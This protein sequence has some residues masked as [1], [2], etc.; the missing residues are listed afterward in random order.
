[1]RNLVLLL[2]FYYSSSCTQ[3]LHALRQAKFLWFYPL[4]RSMHWHWH[5]NIATVWKKFF[6][7]KKFFY[8]IP[9][10]TCAEL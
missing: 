7:K 9:T 4:Y 8:V 6:S 3:M 5:E 1:V 10:S 2:L